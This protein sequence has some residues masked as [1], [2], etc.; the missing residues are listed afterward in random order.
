VSPVLANNGG[1]KLFEGGGELR[2]FDLVESTSSPAGT[3][4]LTYSAT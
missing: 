3:L 1:R 4:F 2:K